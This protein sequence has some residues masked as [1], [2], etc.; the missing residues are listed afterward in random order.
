[1]DAA[2]KRLKRFRESCGS[3]YSIRRVANDLGMQPSSYAYYE[4]ASKFKKQYIPVPLAKQLAALFPSRSSEALALA[5]VDAEN[6]TAAAPL[7]PP[8]KSFADDHDLVPMASIDLEYGMGA[9]F[10][11]VHVEQSVDL[12]PRLWVES[13]S[14]TPSQLLTWARGKGDSMAPTIND[15]DMIL[16]DVSQRHFEE[17]DAIWAMT[18]T[19]DLGMI[20]RVRVRRGKVVVHSDNVSVAPEEYEQ[21]E[22]N[23]VG[24]VVFVGR[25]V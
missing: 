14:R 19:D 21:D 3:D 20:K 23:I 22:I 15:G 1:M 5:G 7:A 24:R 9:T 8:P 6:A 4:D 16:I 2:A 17:Q 18:T 11:N 25:R 10:T 12:F 13:I